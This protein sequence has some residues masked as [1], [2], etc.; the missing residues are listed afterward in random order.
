MDVYPEDH[1]I[2]EDR[3]IELITTGGDAGLA[4]AIRFARGEMRRLM[5]PSDVPTLKQLYDHREG[6]TLLAQVCGLQMI[7]AY[8]VDF[9]ERN[10]RAAVHVSNMVTEVMSSAINELCSYNKNAPERRLVRE[11]ARVRL[12]S[13]ENP[14]E[15]DL[16][17]N[18]ITPYR[19]LFNI[20][21]GNT[22]NRM[23]VTAEVEAEDE[24][25]DMD[26][27]GYVDAAEPAPLDYPDTLATLMFALLYR[28]GRNKTSDAKQAAM[29]TF[30]NK[31][32]TDEDP[33]YDVT[34][35]ESTRSLASMIT[36]AY[37]TL[38]S[39]LVNA[40]RVP[41]PPINVVIRDLEKLFWRFALRYRAT[42]LTDDHDVG[43]RWAR[44]DARWQ[45]LKDTAIAR[46]VDIET[47]LSALKT[48]I[49]KMAELDGYEDYA[50]MGASMYG[51]SEQLRRM[52]A[53]DAAD[54]TPARIREE[55][56]VIYATITRLAAAIRDTSKDGHEYLERVVTERRY[57]RELELYIARTPAA[58]APPRPNIYG[59]FGPRAPDK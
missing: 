13:P 10:V 15:D 23:F 49:D 57:M 32:Q 4:G 11:P 37:H 25:E 5:R 45:G 33:I 8:R 3:L 22:F 26:G 44:M 12:A 50:L 20:V 19:Y 30:I 46:P 56:R 9:L 54:D 27:D 55:G 14:D 34:D 40:S 43:G 17:N 52:R 18:V 38:M 42:F 41:A 36:P 59:Q 51:P 29:M 16:G 31:L 1:M 21:S 35:S 7:G 58:G 2:E 6:R 39:E 28:Q 24:D 53:D 47:H 48:Y